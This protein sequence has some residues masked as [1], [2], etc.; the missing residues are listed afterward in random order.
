MKIRHKIRNPEALADARR[1]M[2]AGADAEIILVF[3]RD[4]EFDQADCIYAIENLYSRQFPEAKRLVVHSQAWS[5]K[6]ES[7]TQL[8]EAAREALRQLGA[9]HSPDLPRIVF[10]DEN[11]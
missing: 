9:S 5:D 10:E 6:Y 2:Q 7:D 11:E 3:L 8:R 1:L 4:R